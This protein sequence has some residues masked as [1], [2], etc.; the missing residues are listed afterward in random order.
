MAS[1]VH[2][3]DLALALIGVARAI[4]DRAR[5]VVLG[6]GRPAAVALAPG[7]RA[8]DNAGGHRW[9]GVH[10]IPWQ[11]TAALAA[12]SVSDEEGWAHRRPLRRG[13]GRWCRGIIYRLLSPRSPTRVVAM[14]LLAGRGG[15]RC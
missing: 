9:S 7:P 13:L 2:G 3:E 10:A 12:A 11:V 14:P 4:A 5:P 15:C 6:G 1:D 8:L